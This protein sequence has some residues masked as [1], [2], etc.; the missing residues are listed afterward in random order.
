M[1]CERIREA[2]A[3]VAAGDPVPAAAEAH[4]AS[5]EACRAELHVLQRAL[6]VADA[7]MARLLAAEPTPE[8]AVRIRQAV[9]ETRDLSPHLPAGIRHVAPESGLSPA[10]RFGWLWPATA[11]AA[12]LLVALAMFLLR[13]TP[14]ATEPRVAAAAGRPQSAGGT[15]GTESPGALVTPSENRPAPGAERQL[16]VPQGSR[17]SSRGAPLESSDEGSA[18]VEAS[19]DPRSKPAPAHSRTAGRGRIPPE[20]EVL[21]PPG[22]GEALL[23]FV[24]LVHRDRLAPS[25]FVAAGRP[26]ADLADPALI[27]IQPLEIVPLDPAETSGT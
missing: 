7:D 25:S 6:A 1:A 26:P 14:S 19:S 12:A 27:D 18:G 15:G 23:R 2:L 4:L 9:A 10:G 5:C 20:P 8:L 22:E 17:S 16:P 21:V 24:A 11:A 3:D 13:G